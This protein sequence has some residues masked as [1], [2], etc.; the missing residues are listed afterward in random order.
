MRRWEG[1]L[2][3][4]D[5][6]SVLENGNKNKQAVSTALQSAPALLLQHQ[7]ECLTDSLPQVQHEAT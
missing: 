3:F 4:L 2:V 5:P 1:N 7:A 6:D